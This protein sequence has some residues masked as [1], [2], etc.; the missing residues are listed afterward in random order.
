MINIIFANF[1][2]AI[3]IIILLIMMSPYYAPVGEWFKYVIILICLIKIHWYDGSNQCCVTSLEAK[4]RNKWKPGYRN[5]DSPEFIRPIFNTL[6]KPFNINL[7][8]TQSHNLNSILVVG[9]ILIGFIRYCMYKK[10]TL[11]PKDR[12]S[13]LIVYFTLFLS[14]IWIIDKKII[15]KN[16][17]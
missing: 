11:F 12:A 16:I 3:H 13:F 9:S 15:T 10:I 2:Y 6:L 1:L 7:N 14:F 17:K 4:F 5:E 8:K